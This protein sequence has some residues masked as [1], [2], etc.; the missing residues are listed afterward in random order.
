M[1][2]RVSHVAAV[3]LAH[4]LVADVAERGGIRALVIKGPV[5]VAQGLRA[6][7]LSADADVL[8]APEDFARFCEDLVARGWH[9]ALYR[10]P[11]RIMTIHSKTFTHD[12]WPCAIDVHHY[13]PGLFGSPQEVFDRL[14]QTRQIAVIAEREIVVPS[15]A[16]MA[17]FVALHALRAPDDPRSP[18]D[19]DVLTTALRERF[20]P[21]TQR[22]FV[23]I[24]RVGRAQWTLAPVLT[25][26]GWVGDDDATVEEKAVWR[27][28]Q[29]DVMSKSALVW[30]REFRAAL[31]SGRI[32]GIVDAVWIPRASMPRRREDTL[33]T[34]RE[35]WAYQIERWRR[36]L[37]I[38]RASRRDE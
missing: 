16:G 4:A 31:R 17:V 28:N 3:A 21:A 12:D 33:P 35:H 24:A 27:D 9:P 29:R 14:W 13:F 15:T 1:T 6:P 10:E 11:P 37:R 23:E 7:R 18:G 30:G 36:G 38:A 8:V 2:V 5:A 26:L 20:G 25:S 34:V 32:R 22:E 19:L